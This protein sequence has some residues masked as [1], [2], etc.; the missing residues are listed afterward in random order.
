MQI[1]GWLLDILACPECH[2]PLRADEAANE[3]VCTSATCASGRS[4]KTR[5]TT[6]ASWRWVSE[7]SAD[8]TAIR[9][10]SSAATSPGAGL[11]GTA[12][13]AR[14]PRNRRRL[15]VDQVF[16]ITRRT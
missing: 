12:A 9:A 7:S 5:R 1:D 15:Q 4:S 13:E 3:L 6:T 16:T 14:S 10:A 8:R 2:A 11:S